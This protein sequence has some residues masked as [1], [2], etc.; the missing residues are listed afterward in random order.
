MSTILK[1][2]LPMLLPVLAGAVT[3]ALHTWIAHGE[4]WYAQANH[5]IQLALAVA[6]SLLIGTFGVVL[7][8]VPGGAALVT[9]C[10]TGVSGGALSQDCL[11][12]IL[13][14]A[15]SP[16]ITL[17]LTAILTAAGVLSAKA[18]QTHEVTVAMA[19]KAGVSL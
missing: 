16:V 6:I 4:S 15:S 9:A 7:Q 1:M 11:N 17:V 3:T 12:A 2:F 14:M 8:G 5:T 13:G 10:A 19:R 18:Q